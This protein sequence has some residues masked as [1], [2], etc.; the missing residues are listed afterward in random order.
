MSKLIIGAPDAITAHYASEKLGA[1]YIWASS[2][3]MSSIL[4]LKDEGMVYIKDFLPLLKGI[5]RGATKPVIL[6]FD[7]G[8]KNLS[9][10]K[11]NLAL[12]KPLQLG[13]VCIEDESWPKKNAML[14]KANRKL[15]PAS[16]MAEKIRKSKEI[17]PSETLV[18]A[19]T[20]SLIVGE[21]VSELQERVNIYQEAG[22]D[23]L[24]IHYTSNDWEWYAKTIGA[25]DI[26]K[27]LLLILSN[28]NF[29]PASLRSFNY[30][31][32]P[33]QIYRMMLYGFAD[34]ARRKMSSPNFK[35]EKM[36]ETKNIFDLIDYI[37]EIN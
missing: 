30:V 28:F 33:N 31:L 32:Y 22:A 27:P 35:G 16:A 34:R 11:S 20:H 36:V 12:L 18:I 29:V 24:C 5:I 7:V 6:D 9:E 19:R 37:H 15:V 14:S 21:S 8:G 26:V 10:F 13:G 2:F 17:L 4:G 1:D 23:V 3:I 25:L